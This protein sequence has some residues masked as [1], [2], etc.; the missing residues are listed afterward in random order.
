[1]ERLLLVRCPELLVEDE[2]GAILR[3]FAG[4]IEAARTYCPWITPVRSGICTL[5]TR[6]P[7]RFFGGEAEVARLV[8]E[9]VRGVPGVSEVQIGIAD[10]LFAAH[11]AAQSVAKGCLIVPAG[12]SVSFLAPQLLSVFERPALTDLL[13]LLGIHHVGAFAALPELHVHRRLGRD[14]ASCHEVA[15]GLTGELPGLRLADIQ[16]R[17]DQLQQKETPPPDQPSFW[18]GHRD[19]DG[20]AVRVLQAVQQLLG[21]EAVMT[22][23]R[24]GGRSPSEQ[25]RLVTW[26]VGEAKGMTRRLEPW[27]GQIPSPSPALVYTTPHRIEVVGSDGQPVAV[28]ARGELAT[29]PRQL[30][31]E[32]G[33]WTAIT[34]WSGPWPVWEQWWTPSRHRSARLQVVTAPGLAH[35]LTKQ[36]NGWWL[37][38]TYD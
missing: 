5:A 35:L 33:P 34:A 26:Q 28:T 20:R 8:R 23:R 24:Q 3:T 10:G 30:S 2:G 29:V 36:R 4:V 6:G 16:H 22:A 15:R 9:A 27:P 1:L 14:G 11:L 12:E 7:A 32:G 37:S 18:G 25:V 38:A 19:G 31:V 17:L 21:A 13:R